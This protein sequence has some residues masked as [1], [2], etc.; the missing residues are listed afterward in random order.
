M[1]GQIYICFLVVSLNIPSKTGDKRRN[2]YVIK[3][4]R[5]GG[6]EDKG[7]VQLSLCY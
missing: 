4:P 7:A 3:N 6:R 2:A 5:G 1:E